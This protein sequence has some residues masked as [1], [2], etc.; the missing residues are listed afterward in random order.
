MHQLHRYKHLLA[1]LQVVVESATEQHI[2]TK[3]IPRIVATIVSELLAIS[4]ISDTIVVSYRLSD[5]CIKLVEHLCRTIILHIV[6]SIGTILRLH[7]PHQR[8]H[9]AVLLLIG[10][11]EC[12]LHHHRTIA[13]TREHKHLEVVTTGHVVG[14][15]LYKSV[16]KIGSRE[17]KQSV[18]K[19]Q[20]ISRRLHSDSLMTI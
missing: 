5:S 1:S 6:I 16:D 18:V 9:E 15:T 8:L 14:L 17:V 12:L 7:I 13:S 20:V 2:D 3:L 19:R 10:E 4:A 11:I